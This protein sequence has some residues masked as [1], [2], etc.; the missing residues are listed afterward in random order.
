M[1]QDLIPAFTPVPRQR[2]RR[3]GWSAERQRQFIALLA[4]TGSVRAAC[5]RMGVG[6]HHI[7]KLRAHPEGESFR[8]AWE[9]ALD[10][11]IAR[12]EDVAMDRALYGTE[13]PVFWQGEQVGTRRVYND[14]LL[15]FLLSNRAPG[16][17]GASGIGSRRPGPDAISPIDEAQRK[18]QWRKEWETERD[19]VTQGELVASIDRKINAIRR[20]IEA[21]QAAQWAKLSEETREAWARFAALRDADLDALAADEEA[22]E[23]VN[24]TPMAKDWPAI[25]NPGP[26]PGWRQ[27]PPGDQ[28]HAKLSR[29]IFL[30]SLQNPT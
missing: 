2:M 26:P 15:M 19:T 29:L 30:C 10:L 3:G 22:R 25:D 5:R 28:R 9:T 14:R 7:Y 23:L 1:T 16:R 17:F 21:E 11:G 8:K 6:E 4:E 27:K 20:R 12:I 18:K 24:V 13:D